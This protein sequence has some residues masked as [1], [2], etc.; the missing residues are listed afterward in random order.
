MALGKRTLR[1]FT[2]DICA[3][4]H[5]ILVIWAI[6]SHA[7][8]IFNL[9]SGYCVPLENRVAR[10]IVGFITAQPASYPGA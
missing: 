9:E 7:M 1:K 3:P 2:I 6:M 4:L 8:R 5:F 10:R